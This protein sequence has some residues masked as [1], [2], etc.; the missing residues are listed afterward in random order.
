MWIA[1]SSAEPLLDERSKPYVFTHVVPGM[2]TSAA[3]IFSGG[4]SLRWVRDQ[5]CKDLVAQAEA[6]G[7]DPYELMTAAAGRSPVGANRLLFNPSLAGGSSLDASPAVRGAFLGLD[8][9]HTQADVI[10][11]TWKGSP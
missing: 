8:L 10:R 2:F 6:D 9:G 11:A 1:V 5:L 3:A 4:S 7:V